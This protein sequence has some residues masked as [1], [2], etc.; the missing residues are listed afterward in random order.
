MKT[1][2]EN[3]ADTALIV[4]SLKVLGNIE[5][6]GL[7]EI[8]KSIE[9]VRR[10][11]VTNAKQ[12]EKYWESLS[13]DGIITSLEKQSLKREMANIE[14]SESAITTQAAALG[15]SGEILDDYVATYEALYTY[16]FETLRLFDD[17]EK[18][19]LIDDR[20]GFNSLFSNYFYSE[21]FVMLAIT[22]GILDTV[23]IRVLSN[24]M[25]SGEEGE[26]AL[27][28]GGLYQYTDGRWKAISTGNYKGARDELP[29]P[30]EDS[31]FLAS[32]DFVT[33]EVLIVNGTELLVNGTELLLSR[34][35]LKGYIYYVQEGVF[36]VEA[37]KSNWRY[38]AAFADVLNVT[39]ELPQIFQD[40]L[41]ALQEQIDAT[42]QNLSETAATLQDEIATKQGK[43]TIIDGDLVLIDEAIQEIVDRANEQAQDIS[44][45]ETSLSTKISHLPEY[46]GPK[47]QNPSSGMLEGDFYLYIGNSEDYLK[48]RRW[49]S[50][51][52]T[53][54]TLSH[55]EQA[56]RN[57]YMIALEDIFA[58]E[59]L[60]TGTFSALFAQSFWTACADI[61][62]LDVQTI[63]LREYGAIQSA[64]ATYVSEDTG[65]RIDA[66]GNIDANGNTHLGASST[67]KVAIGV[68]LYNSQGNL[69][70]DFNDYD[71]VIGGK[72]LFKNDVRIEDSE[73]ITST[74]ECINRTPGERVDTYPA[75]YKMT[76]ELTGGNGTYNDISFKYGVHRTAWSGGGYVNVPEL[77]FDPNHRPVYWITYKTVYVPPS[78]TEKYTLYNDNDEIVADIGNAVLAYDL[79][80]TYTIALNS[81]IMKFKN[82]PNNPPIESGLLW[83]DEN[84]FLKLS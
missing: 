32:D 44:D 70:A 31:F 77:Q 60:S 12:V 36:Y 17:M 7:Y 18:E 24:L 78:V 42:N 82:I 23:N 57:Y 20:A 29:A 73:I 41:D 4:K 65:L 75:G 63:Y 51:Q 74:F 37:D 35:Y 76:M 67:N 38:A 1:R 83:V 55:T 61:D 45:V 9:A 26:T 14:R 15:Y 50:T 64:N 34:Q 16:I 49:N 28:H 54:E 3:K 33:N 84:G 47:L 62:T 22:Q 39:G 80:Y 53:W 6:G 46:L 21:S 2:E 79:V 25:E 66:D 72:V 13:S 56:Y 48:I 58:Q 30:E 69:E 11:S 71:T 40:G 59:Q 43:Y 52:E 19:T 81:K 68:S 5:G 8:K 10:Q 27:Y